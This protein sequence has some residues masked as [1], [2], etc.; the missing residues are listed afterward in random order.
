MCIQLVSAEF[1]GVPRVD[2]R[3]RVGLVSVAIAVV[4]VCAVQGGVAG[5]ASAGLPEPAGAANPG[6]VDAASAADA[7]SAS[8]VAAAYGHAVVVDSATTQ[9]DQVAALPDGTMQLTA[10]SVPV[11]VQRGD[12]WVPVDT[13]LALAS[14][15]MWAPGA[16]PVPVEFTGGGSGPL[17]RVRSADG[18]WLSEVWSAGPLPAPTVSGNTALYREVFAGVDLRVSATVSGMS[19]SLVVKS[20]AAAADPQLSAVSF[21]VSGASLAP[22]VSTA[23]GG[24]AAVS[25]SDGL[26]SASP[27]WW[28]SH[29]AGAGAEGPG[30]TAVPRPVS[31]VV[32]RSGLTVNAAAAAGTPGVAYP[33]YVD[34]DWTGGVLARTFVDSAYPSVSYYNG[35]GASDA[36]QHVGYIDGADSDDGRNHTTRSFWL[37]N[38]SA[39]AGKHV[40]GAAFNTSEVYAYSCSP[41]KV[42]L[43]IAGN[44]GS[45]TTWNNQPA[46]YEFQ[47]Q[48][49]VAYGYNSSCPG[50]SVGFDALNSATQAAQGGWS[51]VALEARADNEGDYFGWKK[52]AAAASLIIT[53]NSYPSVPTGLAFASPP[54]ACGSTSSPAYV[55]NAAQALV[56][57]ARIS[58]PDGG[59]VDSA[60]RVTAN[61]NTTAYGDRE[62]YAASGTTEHAT[63]AAHTY[64]DGTVISWVAVAGDGRDLSAA[65]GPCVAQIDNSAPPLPAVALASGQLDPTVVGQSTR[66]TM[67]SNLADHVVR[68]LYWVSDAA[69]VY[70]SPP[71]PVQFPASGGLPPC[72]SN[73]VPYAQGGLQVAC[74]GADGSATVTVA[75]IDDNST[76]WVASMDAASNFS[77]DAAGRSSASPLGFTVSPQSYASGHTWLTDNAT[78][79]SSTV[80]DS[81]QA[82]SHP[83]SVGSA[84]GW[85]T[86][87]GASGTPTINNGPPA[88]TLAFPGYSE[89][90]RVWNGADHQTVAESAIPAG[91]SYPSVL[92]QVSPTAVAGSEALY[93]CNNGSDGFTSLS[94]TCEG[95]TVNGLLGYGW[96]T[97]SLLPSGVPGVQMYRCR[98]NSSGEHFDSLFADCEGQIVESPLAV[99]AS[100]P[101]TNTSGTVLDTTQSYTV[102]A[103]LY[104][105]TTD[106]AGRNYTALSQGG[107]VNSGFYL[108]L[109]AG[110]QQ[111]RF[112]V[113]SQTTPPVTDCA[114]APTAAT[115]GT[116]QFVAGEWDTAN[117]QVRLYVGAGAQPAA[118]ASHTLPAGDV[119]A[120]GPLTVGSA[121]STGAP[122]NQWGGDIDDPAA[123]QGLADYQ[124]LHDLFTQSSPQ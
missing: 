81:N 109:T 8:A 88:N 71:V 53:Y 76:V 31:D 23:A 83:L 18:G 84:V 28:D 39:I 73:G 97:A 100:V 115:L 10:S 50:H 120:A 34:P 89:L 70:P 47:D 22:V 119:S 5:R 43:Y 121:I 66:V 91:Y 68:F 11:R 104:P 64:P 101:A 56:L 27:S 111:W 36:Y 6:V 57:Q 13:G 15:G 65:S 117:Q 37:M 113:R 20:A 123:F 46:Q 103:W 51:H 87:G 93:S 118:T 95:K 124:Q 72:P 69:P 30:G 61:G 9:T 19:E 107:T 105:S 29:G 17:A 92:G 14:D 99:L 82:T 16:V 112:C 102:A 108:Q 79:G 4:V 52:F 3:R 21:A 58:D 1:A 78:V 86:A 49:N 54:V 110:T 62:G 41:R 59:T 85:D 60:F 106:P 94:A 2:S 75:P 96:S 48:Q 38:T 12:S 122:S 63:I 114:T 26:V 77:R 55:N 44:F 42:D 33:V 80:A 32:S 74:P 90:S 24:A 7:G 40:L 67:S 35:S 116:W 98:M 45:S 25:A